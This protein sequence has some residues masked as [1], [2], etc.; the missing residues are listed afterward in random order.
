[1]LSRH[2]L[3]VVGLPGDWIICQTLTSHEKALAWELVDLHI[4][5]CLPLATVRKKSGDRF[6]QRCEPE[7]PGYVFL[8]GN[9]DAIRTQLFK[10]CKRHIIRF[11]PVINQDQL[12]VELAK[13]VHA[14]TERKEISTPFVPG[15]KCRVISGP[16]AGSEGE[17]DREEK[18]G[19]VMLSLTALGTT[20]AFEIDADCLEPID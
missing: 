14:I 11:I 7:L 15:R 20:C 2:A 5:Y 17:F 8:R 10:L 12:T 6:C 19:R 4:A 13:I 9:P 18:R 1:M 16:Y 3:T